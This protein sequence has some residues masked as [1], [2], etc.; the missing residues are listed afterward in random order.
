[1]ADIKEDGSYQ[2]EKVPVGEAKIAVTNRSLRAAASMPKGSAPP[3]KQ[4]GSISPEEAKRRY[5][6]I[7]TKYETPDTSGLTY[8]VKSGPQEH[9]IPLTGN[10]TPG[11]TGGPGGSMGSGKGSGSGPPKK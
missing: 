9:D 3:G 7:P 4:S 10:L 11:G 6:P 2:V 1:M 8:A 5:V